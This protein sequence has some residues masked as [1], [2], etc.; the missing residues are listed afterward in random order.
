MKPYPTYTK[1]MKKLNKFI[2]IGSG[3]LGNFI[4]QMA[5]EIDNV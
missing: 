5:K 2:I 4:F 1:S 3:Q